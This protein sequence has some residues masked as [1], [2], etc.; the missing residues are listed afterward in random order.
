[1]TRGKH[2]EHF[3]YTNGQQYLYDMQKDPGEENNLAQDPALR[4]TVDELKRKAETGWI[5]QPP[6]KKGGKKKELD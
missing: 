1:M 5:A 2:E 4:A 3:F 6:A